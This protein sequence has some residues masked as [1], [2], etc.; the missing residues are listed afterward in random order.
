[1][2]ID[3]GHGGKDTGAT[4]HGLR[5]SE[6]ALKVSLK[7]A[8]LL[9]DNPRFKVSMTRSTDEKMTLSERTR[10]AN[11]F[12][13]DVFVS[14]HLNSSNDSRAQGKEFYFQNQLP[15][16]EESMYLASRE[17]LEQ[18]EQDFPPTQQTQ[19]TSE[20]TQVPA[21]KLSTQSDLKRILDDLNRNERIQTS[22]ELTKLLFE[23][24]IAGDHSRKAGSRAIRQA[25]FHV[26]SNVNIPSVLI[27]LGF[28]SH[29]QEG[30]R[31]GK[32][33]YQNELA[34]SL[35]DGLVKFKEI[36]DKDQV[37]TLKSAAN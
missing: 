28:L 21:E 11:S 14:I 32:T 22:S 3:P 15:V 30:P 10:R 17:N 31:L 16:D 24:W 18:Q 37:R 12:S 23:T 29:A 19:Q 8:A 6:I 25:P 33:E 7:L 26:V 13:G 34:Q 2:V 36:V 20:P 4:R 5:E 9:K 1:V 27:E 35:Y